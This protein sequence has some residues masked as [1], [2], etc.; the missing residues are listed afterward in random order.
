M[1]CKRTSDKNKTLTNAKSQVMTET[2]ISYIQLFG[3]IQ[4]SSIGLQPFYGGS[5]WE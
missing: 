4:L 1:G 2:R 3:Q 5:K